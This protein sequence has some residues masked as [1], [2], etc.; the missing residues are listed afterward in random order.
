MKIGDLGLVTNYVTAEER[1]DCKQDV[2]TNIPH[3]SHVG[4]RLYMSPEQV[5]FRIKRV[6]YFLVF[7]FFFLECTVK[8][9][10]V[11]CFYICS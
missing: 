3:T 5:V 9:A 8:Y 11:F 7:F 10:V 1:I 6:K 4:T 2:I